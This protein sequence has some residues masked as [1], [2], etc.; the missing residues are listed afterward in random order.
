MGESKQTADVSRWVNMQSRQLH[1]QTSQFFC[2]HSASWIFGQGVVSATSLARHTSSRLSKAGELVA[3]ELNDCL[4]QSS[5]L[6]VIFF[7]P[8]FYRRRF[9]LQ[10]PSRTERNVEMFG[11]IE[12]ALIQVPYTDRNTLT[13]QP[14]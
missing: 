8:S 14:I 7:I 12:R 5:S 10:N 2:R 6:Y 11:A 13:D 9:D 4:F 3:A 1:T